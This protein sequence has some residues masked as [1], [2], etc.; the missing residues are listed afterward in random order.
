MNNKR[1][2]GYVLTR[3]LK[4]LAVMRIEATAVQIQATTVQIRGAV[5]D[6]FARAQAQASPLRVSD[7]NVLA[8]VGSGPVILSNLPPHVKLSERLIYRSFITV[9]V[10][11][12]DTLFQKLAS[13]ESFPIEEPDSYHLTPF[14]YTIWLK[15]ST[16]EELEHVQSD[17]FALFANIQESLK[18]KHSGLSIQRGAMAMSNLTVW[19]STLGMFQESFRIALCALVAYRTL[20]STNEDVYGPRLAHA[21]RLL[22]CSLVDSADFD[23]AYKI[24]TEAVT[25]GRR[26]AATTPTFEAQIQLADLVCY[27]AVV[28][29]LNGDSTNALRD[30]EE[31]A[32]AYTS[33]LGKSTSMLQTEFSLIDGARGPT[34]MTSEGTRV[35]GF[36]A[37]LQEL[38]YGLSSTTRKAESVNAGIKAL[39]LCSALEQGTNHCTFSQIIGELCFSLASDKF[40]GIITC[41]QAL[42]YA[43]QS[44][45]QN[46]KIF[47]HTGVITNYLLDA[48]WLEANLLSSLERYE[49]YVVCQKIE[50]M[51]QSHLNDQQL[52]AKSFLQITINSY[53]S[54][55]Y[56]E[57]ALLGEHLLAMYRSSLSHSELCDAY[58]YTARSLSATGDHLKS[59]QVAEA[60]SN[61]WRPL[62]FQ[63]AEHFKYVGQSL[64]L[65]AYELALAGK[66]NKLSIQGKKH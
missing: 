8:F 21:L 11:K 62:A 27:S 64:L 59:A 13:S 52:R 53:I 5:T 61:H 29:R 37:A 35:E 65:M 58:M 60:A 63:N 10:G 25:L 33:L 24:I 2:R 55:R 47:H 15:P 20:T 3:L 34:V 36:A 31:A 12:I 56:A 4:M 16:E 50:H 40:R 38:H 45:K 32:Q 23:Q 30:A 49:T 54:E 39:E 19:L 18:N 22:S 66:A 51:V 1:V 48:L 6:G 41:D 46:E 9:Q 7:D 17:V 43:Q 42:S 28:G 57:A 26:L 14:E 44:V